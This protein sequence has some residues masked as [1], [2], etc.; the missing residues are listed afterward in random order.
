MLAQSFARV[1]N[2]VTYFSISIF[3][4]NIYYEKR[5]TCYSLVCEKKLVEAPL[6]S[7][8]WEKNNNYFLVYVLVHLLS[9]QKWPPNLESLFKMVCQ[10]IVYAEYIKFHLAEETGW[11]S[12]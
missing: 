11:Y 4:P 6:L 7:F 10:D 5:I 3:I 12:C 2:N 1:R 8:R 9:K